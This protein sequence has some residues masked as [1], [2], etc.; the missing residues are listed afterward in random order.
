LPLAHIAHSQILK[1]T[2]QSMS[3]AYPSISRF[4]AGNAAVQE[5]KTNNRYISSRTNFTEERKHP[6][7]ELFW[8]FQRREMAHAFCRRLVH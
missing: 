2:T 8:S 3:R 4:F 6:T 1:V 7:V 5:A